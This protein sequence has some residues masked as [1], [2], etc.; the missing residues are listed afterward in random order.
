MTVFTLIWN[1]IRPKVYRKKR[2]NEIDNSYPSSW[3][4]GRVI[5]NQAKIW[6]CPDNCKP[7][8]R[9]CTKGTL[10]LRSTSFFTK[11]L[12]KWHGQYFSRKSVWK[13]KSYKPALKVEFCHQMSFL[14]VYCLMTFFRTFLGWLCWYRVTG[15][16][17]FSIKLQQKMHTSMKF[18]MVYVFYGTHTEM[19]I[20]YK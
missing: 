14:A 6:K 2:G 16:L 3:M 19:Q 10:G 18:L 4:T 17:T 12:C 13:H 20:F 1:E 5:E 11:T 7:N 8:K 15:Q 9:G